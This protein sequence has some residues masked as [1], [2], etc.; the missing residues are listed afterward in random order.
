LSHGQIPLERVFQEHD[1]AQKGS[2]NF[3][4]FAMM[5]EFIGLATPKKELK[6]TFDIIDKQKT[7]R[8]RLE[9]IKS[10]SNMI[11]NEGE[12][13]SSE[14]SGAALPPDELKL[15]QELDDLYELIKDRLEKKNTTFE[16]VIYETLKYMPN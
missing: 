13:D 6:R 5:N 12:A 11:T 10:I 1:M 9:D 2:L 7:G 15:R 8:I 14:D 3:E 16:Q 4:D